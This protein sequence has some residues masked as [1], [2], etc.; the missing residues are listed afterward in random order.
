M[1]P[2][3]FYLLNKPDR[4]GSQFSGGIALDSCCERFSVE[5]HLLHL[6]TILCQNCGPGSVAEFR[7]V[8]ANRSQTGP[9]RAVPERDK[10]RNTGRVCFLVV[11]SELVLIAPP[12]TVGGTRSSAQEQTTS[13]FS[14]SRR[15]HN[16]RRRTDSL[17][18]KRAIW[19]TGSKV[20][21]FWVKESN[22]LKMCIL[23][24]LQINILKYFKKHFKRSHNSET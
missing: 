13:C 17:S 6:L 7:S 1:I 22:Y 2:F 8:T 9:E 14:L 23:L 12:H 10:R 4:S 18:W 24:L 11:F 21:W 5:I 15:L 16:G 19:R 20:L 3:L